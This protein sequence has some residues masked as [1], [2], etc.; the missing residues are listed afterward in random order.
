MAIANQVVDPKVS[1]AK[2]EREIRQFRRLAA[3]YRRKGWFLADASFPV[4]VVVLS[5]HRIKPSPLVLGIKFDYTDYDLHPPSVR[6][7]DP[8]S[9][10]PYAFKAL[11]T[12]L[13]RTVSSGPLEIAGL[14]E[15]FAVPQFAQ[16]QT[17]MQAYD[18]DEI[19]FL[20]IPGV[21]EYHE[22]PGHSGDQ[23]ELH[24]GAGA[25]RL[26][27]LV[28]IVDR[29]GVTPLAAYRLEVDV[30]IVGYQQNEVPG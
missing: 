16:H 2:F 12:Q 7:V 22:H 1:R 25:G 5:A 23:W 30:K 17:L 15:G 14:P 20:C 29:Y 21:R 26:S 3:E 19:P 28:E 18:G 8:F 4:A 6:L 13:P 27:R 11:P 24:R 10:E 9:A